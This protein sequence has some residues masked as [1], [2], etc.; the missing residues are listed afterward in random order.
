N[1]KYVRQNGS[2]RARLRGR[3]TTRSGDR[4]VLR[5]ANLSLSR[6]LEY[7]SALRDVDIKS[8]RRPARGH[9]LVNSSQPA[10]A[11]AALYP[12]PDVRYQE[13]WGRRNSKAKFNVVIRRRVRPAEAQL[14][15]IFAWKPRQI[16]IKNLNSRKRDTGIGGEEKITEGQ[17]PSVQ[18]T[19]ECRIA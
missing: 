11:L 4:R 9:G 13:P 5:Y 12:N 3:T 19:G 6:D 15:S 8:T 18:R 7:L 10:A 16:S 2:L 14:K 17:S 1:A